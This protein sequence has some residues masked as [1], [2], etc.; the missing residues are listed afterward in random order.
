M[1]DIRSLV[2]GTPLVGVRQWESSAIVIG[3]ICHF[4]AKTR[5][6]RSVAE[7][8]QYHSIAETRQYDFVAEGKCG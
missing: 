7:T 6:Y 2:L 5:G 3:A 4:I 1:P 8:R